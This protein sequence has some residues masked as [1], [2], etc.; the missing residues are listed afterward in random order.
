MNA[1]HT[2]PVS[3]VDAETVHNWSTRYRMTPWGMA[4]PPVVRAALDAAERDHHRN[5]ANAG[6]LARALCDRFVI[7]LTR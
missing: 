2:N 3:L 1:S 5:G 7:A 6:D 4:L